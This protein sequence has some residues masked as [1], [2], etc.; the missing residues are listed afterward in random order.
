[1]KNLKSISLGMVAISVI[2]FFAALATDIFWLAK[3]VGK[4]FP[5][6]K[7]VEHLV[8][9]A[10]A[11]PDLVSSILLYVGAYGL[12]MQKKFGFIISWVAMGMWIFDALLV[13]NV[14]KFT[15]INFIGPS[16]IF[17]IFSVVYLWRKSAIAQ[18]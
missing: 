7:P 3:L 1:M 4:P 15:N 8:Y 10:F 2:M 18:E 13:L 17:A 5:L 9:E 11:V 12:I 14:T 6:A 16:L